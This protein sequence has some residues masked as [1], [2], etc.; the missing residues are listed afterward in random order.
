MVL[1]P[2]GAAVTVAD[3]APG[4]VPAP[5]PVHLPRTHRQGD[6]FRGFSANVI[7]FQQTRFFM[8]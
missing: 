2:S 8:H 6:T 5:L 1:R 3:G 4:Q 7:D